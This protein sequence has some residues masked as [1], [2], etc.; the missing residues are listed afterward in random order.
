MN[1]I[2]G[3]YGLSSYP[4]IKPVSQ[5][6]IGIV[7]ANFFFDVMDN[8]HNSQS[9]R[10]PLN[11]KRQIECFNDAHISSYITKVMAAAAYLFTFNESISSFIPVNIRTS[12]IAEKALA[13][14]SQFSQINFLY[15]SKAWIVAPLVIEGFHSLK[16][17]FNDSPK[18]ASS[19]VKNYLA[20]MGWI[21]S[22][23]YFAKTFFV[24]LN[25]IGSD[26][27]NKAIIVSSAAILTI[28]FSV[29]SSRLR[30]DETKPG[31]PDVVLGFLAS[32]ILMTSLILGFAR[33]SKNLSCPI[34]A[35]VHASV[36]LVGICSTSLGIVSLFE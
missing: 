15:S 10:L 1:V 5:L 25:H 14:L 4:F 7:F 19:F 2:R 31:T 28:L 22:S 34:D 13:K 26:T 35:S 29:V 9:T 16:L 33:F 18:R 24:A 30:Q 12:S 6:L 17:Y 32:N 27:K 20:K 23:T 3:A 11:D 21:L 36:A 8:A